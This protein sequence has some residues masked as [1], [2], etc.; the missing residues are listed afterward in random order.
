MIESAMNGNSTSPMTTPA[1]PAEP[2]FQEVNT[3]SITLLRVVPTSFILPS[4]PSSHEAAR[5][6]DP[7]DI[8]AD[9][10]ASTPS[11]EGAGPN[12]LQT[13]LSMRANE[14]NYE[15][16]TLLAN[17]STIPRPDEGLDDQ[18]DYSYFGSSGLPMPCPRETQLPSTFVSENMLYHVSPGCDTFFGNNESSPTAMNSP[19]ATAN[20]SFDSSASY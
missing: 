11:Q 10:L 7:I 8:V 16:K 14:V 17:G 15:T 3:D 1:S 2:I 20:S 19:C 9:L 4:A 5:L 13:S 6:A 12:S 18:F